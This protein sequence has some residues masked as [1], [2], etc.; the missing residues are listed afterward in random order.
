M[1]DHPQLVRYIET[2]EGL[3]K[4]LGKPATG[5]KERWGGYGKSA[6][7]YEFNGDRVE[8][9]VRYALGKEQRRTLEEHAGIDEKDLTPDQKIERVKHAGVRSMLHELI[10][11]EKRVQL[12]IF[13]W[14]FKEILGPFPA[15]VK[16]LPRPW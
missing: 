12:I 4:K 9:I 5:S 1:T 2:E 13:E 10:N 11:P 16:Y 8:L 14:D 7:W 15:P 3:E 6:E